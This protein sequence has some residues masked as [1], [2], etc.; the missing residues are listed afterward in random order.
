MENGKEARERQKEKEQSKKNE[1]MNQELE[2]LYFDFI[3]SAS[4]P[5]LDDH[6]P[7]KEAEK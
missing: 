4:F 7:E 5:S 6:E 3:L 1:Y 2:N